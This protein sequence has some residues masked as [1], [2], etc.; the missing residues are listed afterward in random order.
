[1]T[2]RSFVLA[3]SLAAA[4][5]AGSAQAQDL[6][7]ARGHTI[8]LGAVNGVAYYTVENGGFRV[9]ATLAQPEGQPVRLET[10]LVPGQ[11]VVL[12][13][14]TPSGNAPARVEISRNADDLDVHTLDVTN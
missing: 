14:A 10:V 3:A 11:S 9:V 13:T 2:I 6:A 4:A 1:M 12:S 7:P 8:N 5:L